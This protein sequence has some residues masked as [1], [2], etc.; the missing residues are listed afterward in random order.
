MT[1]AYYRALLTMT[2]HDEFDKLMGLLES[3]PNPLAIKSSQFEEL[4]DIEDEPEDEFDGALPLALPA[5]PPGEVPR[6]DVLLFNRMAVV[7]ARGAF[8]H[9]VVDLRSEW[10]GRFGGKEF[11]IYFGNCSHSSGKQRAFIACRNRNHVAC[12][13]NR[14]L[15]MFPNAR[16]CCAWLLAW[17]KAGVSKGP[18]FTK[19]AHRFYEPADGEVTAEL[20]SIQEV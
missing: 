20:D 19:E 3:A 8:H 10:V 13:K 7:A 5:I 9:S 6:G 17:A 15:D 2:N 1:A 12:F 18:E 4:L 14:Q 11:K 16:T